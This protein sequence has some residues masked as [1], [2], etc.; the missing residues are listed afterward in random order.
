MAQP[1]RPE[2]FGAVGN[3]PGDGTGTDDRAA[4]QAAL[5]SGRRVYLIQNKTY[6]IGGTLYIPRFQQLIG[7]G[8]RS[9]SE[10]FVE[11]GQTG[12]ARLVFTGSG[13]GCFENQDPA[14][15]LSHGGM[16]GFVMR[17]IGSYSHMMY[18]RDLLDWHMADIG[19]QTDS[20][21]MS[22]NVRRLAI[23]FWGATSV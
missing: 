5:N 17:A 21:T 16:R 22:E 2:D 18:F 14:E 9:A 11:T 10:F 4:F 23:G 19:M 13:G 6:R 12:A 1:P 7:L 8:G 15:M 3:D 20:L